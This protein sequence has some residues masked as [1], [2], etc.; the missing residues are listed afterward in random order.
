MG[1]HNRKMW[2]YKDASFWPPTKNEWRIYWVF[3]AQNPADPMKLSKTSQAPRQ[4]QTAPAI[5]QAELPT[6]PAAQRPAARELLGGKDVGH[7]ADRGRLAQRAPD[8]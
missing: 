1:Y 3:Q 6:D 2:H 8:L 5:G 4:L 7:A